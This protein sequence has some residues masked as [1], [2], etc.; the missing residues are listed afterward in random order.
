VVSTREDAVN[1]YLTI[2]DNGIG[3]D[4]TQRKNTLGL[5]GLRERAVSLNGQLHIKSTI[6]KG[7]TVFAVIPKK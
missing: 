3:F 1:L 2:T 4:T 6:G 5:I 7:T